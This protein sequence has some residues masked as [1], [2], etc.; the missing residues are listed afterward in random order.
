M[1]S[2]ILHKMDTEY[3]NPVDYSF[4][5]GSHVVSLNNLINQQI[6]LK[7]NG[8]VQ[9]MCGKLLNLFYS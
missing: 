5:V 9:C 3:N 1:Y 4:I 8:K 6:T 2:G 7:W